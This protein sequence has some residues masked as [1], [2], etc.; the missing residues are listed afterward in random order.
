MSLVNPSA[1]NPSGEDPSS[2]CWL[3]ALLDELR[4]DIASGRS[5]QIALL[6]ESHILV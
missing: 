4:E 5:Y 6:F 3:S 1:A 2:D